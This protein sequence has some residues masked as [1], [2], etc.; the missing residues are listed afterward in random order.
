MQTK[1][2]DV[3]IVGGGLAGLGLAKQLKLNDVDLD[4]V[5]IEQRQFPVPDTTA[6]VGES[7][8]EIGSHY[9]AQTLQLDDHFKEKHLQKHGLRCFFGESQHNYAQQD[10]LGVSQLFGIPTYQI[11][12]GV[13]ENH[14]HH[15][16]ATMGIRVVDNAKTNGIEL[17]NKQ[18]R[19]QL[20][21]NEEK[22]EY[23]S[24]WLIDAAGRQSLI[25]NKLALHKDS[26]HQ[27][28]AIWFRIDKKIIIDQWS[29]DADWRNRL[30]EPGKR[31]LSTN[32]LMGPGYW[33]WIIPL[34]SGATSIGIVL[35][36]QA[37][38]ASNIHSYS[39]ALRWLALHQS[40]CVQAI[41]DAQALD[42]KIIR[43][44]SFSCKKMFSDEG[45]A[46]TGEAGVFADP[47]Y[48]PGSDFI[49]MN[50]T[51]IDHLVRRDKCGKDICLENAI[52]HSLYNSFF[53]STLSL[54]AN[55]YGGF[56][57]RKMMAIKLLWD[58]GYYW[59]V[60]TL[61]FF[62]NAIVDVNVMRELNPML[63]RAQAANAEIQMHLRERAKL[64]LVLPAQGLFFDQYLVPCLVYFNHVL[65]QPYD[66]E[67]VPDIHRNVV[68][69]E[70]VA[71]FL[72]S[73]LSDNA[74]SEISASERELL[75]DYRHRVLA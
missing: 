57:D 62:R 19:I 4:I 50:N 70:Q 24:R 9:L 36:D 30:K 64:R 21:V 46:L 67:V 35:D 22:T 52:F 8:V 33:V 13:L 65:K 7:T 11:E 34:G 2:S 26:H 47:F 32:H 23:S 28:N 63:L 69:L 60:L 27:G 53:D 16:L 39:D 18:Q 5:V 3:V 41:G 20:T 49:A 42:F 44:Y 68:L 58:Y 12:R 66:T 54:Y 72:I 74:T 40:A 38:E 56:G 45:W 73:M 55:E 10:E 71:G 31:W 61:L 25:K 75:G 1:K 59:G 51:F 29:V 15:E 37:F 43:G 48:S 14:L 17:G 6:K